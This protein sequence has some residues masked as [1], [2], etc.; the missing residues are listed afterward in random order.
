MVYFVRLYLRRGRR[1]IGAGRPVVE[2]PLLLI[3]KWLIGL[4]G[5]LGRW[6]IFIYIEKKEEFILNKIR[7]RHHGHHSLDLAFFVALNSCI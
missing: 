1:I 2:W 5:W 3:K 7:G 6:R 4:L